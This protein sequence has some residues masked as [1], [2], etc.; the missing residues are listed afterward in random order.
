MIGLGSCSLSCSINSVYRS[1]L[2][3]LSS[4]TDVVILLTISF[5]SKFFILMV[6]WP[7]QGFILEIQD[8]VSIIVRYQMNTEWQCFCINRGNAVIRVLADIL[9]E[10]GKEK[11]TR[12][13]IATLRVRNIFRVSRP[14]T[15]IFALKCF[16]TVKLNTYLIHVNIIGQYVI[17]KTNGS[18]AKSLYHSLNSSCFIKLRL[19]F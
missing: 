1:K 7:L 5:L 14:T 3:R 12:I 18:P 15:R 2:L 6:P 16:N 10:S 4:P 11:V 13:I 9:R 17:A 8:N 19:V